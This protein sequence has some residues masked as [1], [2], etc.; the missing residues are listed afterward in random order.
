MTQHV[1]ADVILHHG[2]FTTLD[3]S[4]PTASSVAVKDG[5]FLAATLK[6]WP[7]Q[8]RQPKSST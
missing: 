8:V 1:V 7:S 2:L 3:K 4:N 5:K 6:L